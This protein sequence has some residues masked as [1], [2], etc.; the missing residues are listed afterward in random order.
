MA[1]AVLSWIM[2]IP[3]LGF[4][5]GLRTMTPM[6]IL[7]WFAWL[8]YMP[9]DGTWAFWVAKLPTALIFT[10]LAVSELVADKLPKIGDRTSPG[11]LA[12]RLIFAGLIGAII[13]AGLNGSGIEGVFLAVACSLA[14]AFCG[15]LLR[16]ELVR[17]Y[18]FKD[19][20]VAVAEDIFTVGCAILAMGVITG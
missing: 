9:V 20:Y 16:R 15:F 5:T 7:C 19:W 14:G 17:Q 2:A 11:P 13:A 8:G 12:A 6:A 3:L 1:L 10:L 4:V 18:S